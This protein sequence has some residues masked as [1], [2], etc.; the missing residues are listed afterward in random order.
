MLMVMAVFMLL[1]MSMFMAMFMLMPVAMPV[2]AITVAVAGWI[3][4]MRPLLHTLAVV[5]ESRVLT[6]LFSRF[7]TGGRHSEAT[8]GNN[9]GYGKGCKTGNNFA[10]QPFST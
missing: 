1:S 2:P 5:F 6:F 9:S 4:V 7:T 10:R 3:F 8:S